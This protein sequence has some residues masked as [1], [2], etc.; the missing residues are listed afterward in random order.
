MGKESDS[1]LNC[2]QSATPIKQN[3]QLTSLNMT[4]AWGIE[5][6]NIVGKHPKI[7][8][9]C[10][11]I[12]PMKQGYRKVWQHSMYSNNR[13]QAGIDAVLKHAQVIH[14]SRLFFSS[15]LGYPKGKA[16]MLRKKATFESQKECFRL[17]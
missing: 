10:S 12:Q 11:K 3:C 5:R 6:K 13:T 4:A 7:L 16:L 14:I 15:K 2:P 17:C 9:C 8:L 1:D